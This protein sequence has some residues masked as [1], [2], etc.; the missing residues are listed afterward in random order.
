MSLGPYA[1]FIVTAYT[2]VTAVVA[3]LIAWIGIDY[4]RLYPAI[5]CDPA[6]P[7]DGISAGVNHCESFFSLLKR[8]VHGAWHSERGAGLDAPLGPCPGDGHRP[9]VTG[10]GSRLRLVSASRLE[11]PKK[12]ANP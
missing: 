6:K 2:V 10:G 7:E 8:G 11:W 3:I 1:S 4:R 9:H 5:V 12:P